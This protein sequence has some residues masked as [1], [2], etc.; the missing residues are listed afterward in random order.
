M[1]LFTKQY[2]SPG[3]M[4]GTLAEPVSGEFTLTLQDYNDKEIA[5][6]RDLTPERCRDYLQTSNITWIHLQGNPTPAVLTRL[7]DALGIHALHLEDILNTGQRPK[8]DV[9]EDR[10][11]AILSLP[12]LEENHTLVEQVCLFLDFRTV[13]SFCTGNVN[14]FGLVNERLQKSVGKMRKLGGDYLF[15]S[16][17]DTVIDHGFP[18]LEAYA[19]RVEAIEEILLDNPNESTLQ[20][21]HKLRRDLLL[22]RRRLW[23]NREVINAL[24]RDGETIG[25]S[26]E[27]VIYLR[28]CY[29]HSIAILELLET[30]HEMTAGMLEVYLSSLSNRLNEVMR[31]LTVIATLFI[32]PTFLVGV[33]GMNFDR[34]AGPFSM[35]ELSWPFGYLL[36]WLVIALMIAG[37]LIFFRRK[38]WF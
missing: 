27:T 37:M 25:I 34:K 22:L 4:P 9:I 19:E 8:L 29:D 21:V 23:P 20:E 28:D 5:I 2:S 38:R 17:I 24:I 11:F 10:A 12:L 33:Y 3:T 35:P 15:Y 36:V 14:P 7:G 18:V 30:Y 32:P 16:L 6:E 13:V 31:V 1:E 26:D